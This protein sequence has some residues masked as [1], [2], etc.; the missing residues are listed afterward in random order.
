MNTKNVSTKSIIDCSPLE[1]FAIDAGIVI[2]HCDAKG[3]LVSQEKSDW[4]MDLLSASPLIR[5]AITSNCAVWNSQS[6]LAPV[7]AFQG[8]WLVPVR[9]VNSRRDSGLSIGVIVTDALV[10]SEYL[11]ALCQASGA[12]VKVIRSLL[13]SFQPIATHDVKRIASMFQFAW[14]AYTASEENQNTMESVGHELADS[15][16]EISLLYTITGSMNSVN[17]PKRFVEL[18]CNELLQTLP[19]EWIGVQ[20]RIGDRLPRIGSELVFAGNAPSD[21][22]ETVKSISNAIGTSSIISN[23]EDS[24]ANK[25]GQATIIEPILSD[26]SVIGVLVAANK[27]G[28]DLEASSVDAKLLSATAAQLAIF[29]ENA[30]LYEDLSA[31]FLGT[32]EALTASIDAK[33]KYTCGHSQRVALLTAQ[34]AQSAGLDA[35]QVDRFRIAGL[36]HDIGKIGVPEHVLTKKGGLTGAEFEEIRK[37]PEIG[38]KILKDIPQMEDILGGVLHHH[39]KYAG[40]GYPQGISGEDIPLVARMISLA[41]TF[42]AMSSSRTYRN[43]MN[44]TAVLDEMRQVVGS[45][46]DPELAE[47][48]FKLDFS[49]WEQLMIDHQTGAPRNTERKAA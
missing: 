37:H 19:Y 5:L 6:E 28:N 20:L 2:M 31:T 15:Y 42:D 25:L 36:V 22:S 34:L 45:Q 47:L 46:F 23:Y 18:A 33:D 41:D 21:I 16:E 11:H 43:A 9:Q 35:D 8:V 30:L 13:A 4:L 10:T 39:E 7:E 12:D 17:H 26:G 27:Q 44:R 3:K 14:N 1:S 38:A 49:K 29:L 32:L 24:V 48:F 40:G